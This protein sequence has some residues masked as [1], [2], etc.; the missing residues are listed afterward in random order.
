M[1]TAIIIIALIFVIW[2]VIVFGIKAAWG[3]AKILAPVILLPVIVIALV[4]F[5]LKYIA[6]PVVI[7]AGIISIVGGKL[8]S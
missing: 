4:Y 5:G 2:K 6:L 1:F 3:I 8:D 7:I